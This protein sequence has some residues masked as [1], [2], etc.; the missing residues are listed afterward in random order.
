MLA[1]AVARFD[2]DDDCG[3]TDDW[4]ASCMEGNG[5]LDILAYR[6][7]Y[8]VEVVVV[9]ETAFDVTRSGL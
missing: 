3:M 5:G 8:R 9:F 7:A 4:Y 6:V 1:T 2:E